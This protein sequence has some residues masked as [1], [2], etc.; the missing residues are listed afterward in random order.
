MATAKKGAGATSRV[1]VTEPSGTFT[2]PTRGPFSLEEAATF[3]FGHNTATEFDGV[4]RMAFCLD[5]SSPSGGHYGTH[6]GVEVRQDGEELH[7]TAYGSDDLDR[8]GLPQR[9][10]VDRARGPAPAGLAVAIAHAGG[11]AAYGDA[12]R[13][14]ETGPFV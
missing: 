8:I 10:P 5:G 12:H 4:M 1:L 6:V 13:P 7:C 3:G 9:E 2:L 11:L 14:A